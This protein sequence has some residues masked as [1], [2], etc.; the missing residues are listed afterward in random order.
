MYDTVNLWLDRV[1]TSG[2]NPFEVLPYLT[3]IT[4]RK[5]AQEYSCTGTMKGYNVFVSNRGLWMVGSLAK[6][7]FEGDNVPTMTRKSTEL[8]IQKLCDEFHTDMRRA[9]VKRIDVASVI[10]TKRPPTDYYSYLGSKAYFK[11]LQAAEDT[12]YY[13]NHQRQLVFYDKKKESE[14]VPETWKNVLRYEYS[15]LSHINKQMRADVRAETIYMEDFYMKAVFAWRDEFNG[16]QKIKEQSFNMDNITTIR[17][18]ETALLA[19]F[20]QQSGQ[21]IIDEFL[22]ELKANSIFKERPRYSELKKRLQTVYES[23]SGTKSE[24]VQ[25]LESAVNNIARYAR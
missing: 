9:H 25:E 10:P 11:R 13:K 16:I 24:L 1:D 15:L 4:E 8:A 3:G 18:A 23:P 12:L 19:Y 5:N 21:G 7:F 20:L 22:N 2:G 17:D 14:T 6:M